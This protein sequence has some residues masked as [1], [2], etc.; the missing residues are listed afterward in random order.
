MKLSALKILLQELNQVEFVLP[1]GEKVPEHFHVTEIGKIEKTFVDCGGALRKEAVINF[2]LWSADDY[3][4]RL[5]A[6]KLRSIVD[7]SEKMLA[8]EE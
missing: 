8:L 6:Q 7:V 4:Q 3:N 5:S 1:N 2:Q